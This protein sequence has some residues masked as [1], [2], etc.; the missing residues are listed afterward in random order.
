MRC[1]PFYPAMPPGQECEY[2]PS[3]SSLGEECKLCPHPRIVVAR[4]DCQ[5]CPAGEGPDLA[6]TSCVPCLGGTSSAFGVCEGCPVGATSN[7]ARTE[8][9]DFNE[10]QDNTETGTRDG[11]CDMLSATASV[12]PCTN[13]LYTVGYGFRC[14]LCP[15]GFLTVSTYRDYTIDRSTT[16]GTTR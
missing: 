4:M 9:I 3:F 12:D 11:G 2:G 8:C 7:N 10:C 13:D 14:S 16:H 1:N 6:H 5:S 15:T